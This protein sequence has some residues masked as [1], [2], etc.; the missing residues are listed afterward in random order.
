MGMILCQ[1]DA[2]PQI[3]RH[4]QHHPSRTYTFVA[5]F[6][7]YIPKHFVLALLL[8]IGSISAPYQ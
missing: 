6:F 4:V 1:N 2:P 7:F 3:I 8:H 5:L